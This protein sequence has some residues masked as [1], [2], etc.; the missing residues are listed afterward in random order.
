MQSSGGRQSNGWGT[1]FLLNGA[2]SVL[3]GFMILAAPELLAYIVAVFFILM[4]ITLMM[5]GWKIRQA[6]NR[7]N[8]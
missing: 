3:F 7:G 5:T 2:I 4:G 8:R 6:I 1:G